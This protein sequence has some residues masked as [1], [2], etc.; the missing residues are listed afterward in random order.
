MFRGSS[1]PSNSGWDI[2]L[3]NQS[4]STQNPNDPMV[5]VPLSILKSKV[6]EQ[7]VD[8]EPK[9]STSTLIS[10]ISAVAI[11]IGTYFSFQ[12]DIKDVKHDI[13]NKTKDITHKLNN[14]ETRFSNFNLSKFENDINNVRNNIND[15]NKNMTKYDMRK[16]N[17]KLEDISKDLENIKM[18]MEFNSENILSNKK[19]INSFK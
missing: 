13:E 17:R 2:D 19:D 18:K 6:V 1:T 10:I 7:G 11:I 15:V 12:S 9:F 4:T 3:D 5:N 8:N 14:I 16:I